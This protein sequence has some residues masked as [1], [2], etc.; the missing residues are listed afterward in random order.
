LAKDIEAGRESVR[1]PLRGSAILE[2]PERR[3][4]IEARLLDAG[5]TDVTIV[6]DHNLAGANRCEIRFQL[7]LGNGTFRGIHSSGLI[8]YCAFSNS[9]GGFKA[10]VRLKNLAAELS[11][12]LLA[13]VESGR[14]E[15]GSM[16]RPSR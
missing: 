1:R 14:A 11:D 5:P 4:I 15:R 7:P 9:A 8:V 13:Y 10:G 2:L 12:H 6:C 3:S 16:T